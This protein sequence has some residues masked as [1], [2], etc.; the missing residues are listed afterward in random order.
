VKASLEFDRALVDLRLSGTASEDQLKSITDQT[1]R[2]AEASGFSRTEILQQA[3]GLQKLGR[4]S[5]DAFKD[6]ES[7]THYAKLM[8]TS[9][10][11]GVEAQTKISQLYYDDT[12][13]MAEAG[14]V[15]AY[16][17]KHLRIP[18]DEF[19]SSMERL[20]PGAK[21]SNTSL[22]DSVG[23]LKALTEAGLPAERSAIGLARVMAMSA[24]VGLSFNDA[25]EKIRQNYQHTLATKGQ[26]AADAYLVSETGLRQTGLIAPLF[27]KNAEAF[28]AYTNGAKDVADFT[29]QASQQMEAIPAVKL[30]IAMNN[31]KESFMTLATPLVTGLNWV[32]TGFNA[33]PSL[34]KTT[35]IAFGV[36]VAASFPLI[37]LWGHFQKIRV[38]LAP[39]GNLLS[40]VFAPLT[41]GLGAFGGVA[42]AV[43]SKISLVAGALW[44]LWK[45]V[46][47]LKIG[48]DALSLHFEKT[49]FEHLSE[50]SK[51]RLSGIKSSDLNSRA[52]SVAGSVR[53]SGP[54]NN[55][56][57][58]VNGDKTENSGIVLHG[59]M[60]VHVDGGK[61]L[62]GKKNSFARELQQQ[63]RSNG[64]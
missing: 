6:V 30:Q 27:M 34:I 21:L 35:T 63:I 24:R 60:H 26:G 17:V 28:K 13:H 9:L 57:S 50:S 40:K 37:T 18:M 51:E 23:F 45:I 55:S 39:L 29:N 11:E 12:S 62:D 52:V 44:G 33:L 31:L 19:V 49:G 59:D 3:T 64:R 15:L 22:S 32:L 20:G 14:N 7:A 38:I 36:L 53:G 1:L 5:A 2:L 41:E 8:N 48:W 58:T 10:T 43:L 61:V 56:T 16:S 25:L 42:F 54:G 46:Q 47:L 4:S